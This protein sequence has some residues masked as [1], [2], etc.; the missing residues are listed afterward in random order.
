MNY[1]TIQY[2]LTDDVAVVTLNRPE[3][4]NAL[5]SQM[6]AEITDAVRQ[7]G[8]DGRVVVLTGTGGAFCSG[9]DLSDGGNAANLDLE[10]TLRDEY[11]PMLR[12]IIDCPVPTICAVNGAAAGAGAN[13]AL[14]ADVVIA[15]QS[16]FFLQAFT[17]IGL[18]PDAGGTWFLPRQMGLAKSMGAALF[19]EKITAQQADDWGLIWEA[20]A[21]DA[22]E[23]HWKARAAH[24]AKG[25]SEAYRHLKTALWA[26]F[27]NTIDEQLALE[28]RLQ[29]SCGKTRDFKEGIMAFLEKRPAKY[30]GR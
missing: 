9:Q 22:F 24:L 25:P 28:A 11:V 27:D 16:A 10:R 7:G 5:S 29:G 13:L 17:R 4:M 3:V 26:S 2:D 8:R 6:R 14:V 12:A 19:A 21:D 1:D 15:T 23:A 20:V 30:E 18:I